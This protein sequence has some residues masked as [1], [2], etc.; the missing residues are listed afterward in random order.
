MTLQEAINSGRKI[1][2]P[3]WS[4]YHD[5]FSCDKLYISQV[6]RTD[7]EIEPI[8]EK[9]YTFT[10]SQIEIALRESWNSPLAKQ[11][12]KNLGVEE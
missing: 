9:T 11:L 7:W 2:L 6:F 5:G 10:K 8:P 1:K 3:E 12:F 4:I